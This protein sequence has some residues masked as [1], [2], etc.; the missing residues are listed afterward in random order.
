M[1]CPPGVTSYTLDQA[2]VK[3]VGDLPSSFYVKKGMGCMGPITVSGNTITLK[4][5]TVT[6]LEDRL[7]QD[8]TNFLSR[9]VRYT[10]SFE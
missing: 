7:K 9:G 3:K 8:G 1:S 6:S 10:T 5:E 2:K 4:N